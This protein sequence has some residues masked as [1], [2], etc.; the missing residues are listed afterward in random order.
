M[1][2]HGSGQ[3]A[4]EDDVSDVIVGLLAVAIGALLC[5]RGYQAMRIVIA[6]WGAFAGFLLGA[7]LVA[8][9]TGDGFLATL[10]AW[11]V[12]VGLGIVVGL[13]AY[14]YYA[15][16]VI[17]AMGAI[18]FALGTSLMVALGVTW[19]W[20]IVLV[21]VLVG[22]LLAMVAIVGDLPMVVLAVLTALAGAS[23]ILGGVLLLIGSIATGDLSTTTTERLDDQWWWWVLYLGLAITGMVL[24]MRATDRMRG[25][26]RESWAGDTSV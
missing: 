7:S 13:I 2:R 15:V 5:F 21:G 20:L 17:I 3:R 1:L 23:V 11:I 18:G 8:S 19:S 24:Q 12:A 4:T 10:L 26:L 6:V 14:L 25:S 22:V 9:F 16:S